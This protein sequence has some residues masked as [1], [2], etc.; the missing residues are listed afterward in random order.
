VARKYRVPLPGL[1]KQGPHKQ[2][3]D[4]A[5]SALPEVPDRLL[6]PFA[7]GE[8]SKEDRAKW[9]LGFGD[10]AYREKMKERFFNKNPWELR[11]L[12]QL[13]HHKGRPGGPR[14]PGPGRK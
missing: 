10:P 5:S 14:G 6:Y 11:R 13:D 8:T 4:N 7:L 9:P 12:Q 2:L 3:W 1:D